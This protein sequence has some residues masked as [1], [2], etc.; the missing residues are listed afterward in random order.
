MAI[1][2][3]RV[4][5]R[6]IHG[7]V[8]TRWS[9]E[10]P[11]DGLLAV[12]DKAATDPILK[13]ALKSA[14]SKKTLIYTYDE[15]LTKMEQAVNSEKKYFIITKD[16]ITQQTKM[17]GIRISPFIWSMRTEKRLIFQTMNHIIIAANTIK[18]T[19]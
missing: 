17:M 16:P 13:T 6:I 5:D 7:Q 18:T 12:N 11:C 15:F 8:V 1:S 4:D 14:S 9:M 3:V 2:F 19:M 10:K